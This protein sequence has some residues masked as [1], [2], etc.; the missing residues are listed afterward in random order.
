VNNECEGLCIRWSFLPGQLRRDIVAFTGE[1]AGDRSA[2]IEIQAGQLHKTPPSIVRISCWTRDQAT[3]L[4][5]CSEEGVFRALNF[6]IQGWARARWHSTCINVEA[7][8][9]AAYIP[10][11]M[12]CVSTRAAPSFQDHGIAENPSTRGV[13]ADSSWVTQLVW[14]KSAP[15]VSTRT[16]SY[17]SS[18]YCGTLH[19]TD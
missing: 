15:C 5:M 3:P 19:R 14:P 12:Q 16:C 1:T 11:N 4:P 9:S 6:L 10:R 13:S 8:D 2:R 17:M 7:N 18:A